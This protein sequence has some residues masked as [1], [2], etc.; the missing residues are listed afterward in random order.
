MSDL[1]R[2]HAAF[3][4]SMTTWATAEIRDDQARVRPAPD[5]DQLAAQLDALAPGWSL[6]WGC[7]ATQPYV[8]RARLS[9]GG[10]TREGLAEGPTLN[11]ARLGALADLA[12]LFGLSAGE[13]HWVEY[14][15]EEGA[16]TA[17]LETAAR[18]IAPDAVVLPPEP[19]RDPQMDKARS[20][21]EELVEQLKA[22]GKGGAAARILLSGYGETLEESRAV[23]RQLKTLLEEEDV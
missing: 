9:A 7:D 14:D 22:A 6:T 1:S 23:Y 8:V 18:P 12:R 11:D 21:I 10:Q 16:N 3:Q 20:H 5:L 4:S 19:P 13:S 17:E 15:P 2:V